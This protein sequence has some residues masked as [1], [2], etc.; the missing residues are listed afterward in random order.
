MAEWQQQ[1]DGVSVEQHRDL[2]T[3]GD[4]TQA[5]DLCRRLLRTANNLQRVEMAHLVLDR[6][7]NGGDSSDDVNALL[8]LLGNYVSPTRELTEEILSLL[9]FCDHRVLLIHHLPKPKKLLLLAN[10]DSV[11]RTRGFLCWKVAEVIA[12]RFS[13]L[14][15]RN[16]GALASSA[17]LFLDHL[18]RI[19]SVT[20]ESEGDGSYPSHILDLLCS[21]MALLT[22]RER[23]IYSLLMITIQKQL[24]SRAGASGMIQDQQAFRIQRSRSMRRDSA[25]EV[26]QLMAVFLTGHLL[27][28]QVVV[29]SRDRKSLANWML[30][31]LTSA[32]RDETLLHVMRFVRDE[33][34]RTR[35]LS[36]LEQERALLTSAISQVFRKKGLTWIPRDE[37]LERIEEDGDLVLAFD[38]ARRAPK[39]AK[40]GL[41][42]PLVMD[43][44]EFVRKMQFGVPPP[45]FRAMSS[46]DR[47]AS[48]KAMEQEYL[49]KICLLRELFH[50]YVEFS[51][52]LEMK[53]VD[54]GVLLPSGYKTAL[55]SESSGSLAPSA[56]SRVLWNLV[57]TLDVSVASTNSIAQ[58]YTSVTTGSRSKHESAKHYSRLAARLH[59]CLQQ[60]DQLEHILAVQKVNI[61]ACLESLDD[62]IADSRRAE[63][64]KVE[65]EWLLLEAS[66]A[67][68]MLNGQLRRVQGELPCASLFGLDF[69]VLCLAFEGQWKRFMEPPLS[70]SHELELLRAFRRHLQSDS[71]APSLVDDRIKCSA[72]NGGDNQRLLVSRSEGR[73]AVKYLCS[74]AA[75]LSRA[76]NN[77]EDDQTSGLDDE[78]A[79]DSAGLAAANALLRDVMTSSLTCIYETFLII[80]E[81]SHMSIATGD[82]S[83]SSTMME[84]LATGASSDDEVSRCENPHACNETFFRHLARQCLEM[85]ARFCLTCSPNGLPLTSLSNAVV[86]P[87][88]GRI[89]SLAK[90]RCSSPRWRHIVY[91]VVGSWAF[92]V[93]PAVGSLLLG[94]YLDD[95]RVLVDAAVSHETTG[96][97]KKRMQGNG[98]ESDEIELDEDASEEEEARRQAELAV[99]VDGEHLVLK[100]LTNES[101]P[102]FLDAV[103]LC[104]IASLYRAAPKRSNAQDLAESNPFEDYCRAMQ[105]FET[106]LQVF[107][108][109]E[110]SGFNLPVKTN[111]LVLRGGAFVTRSAK[112]LI[113]KCIAWRVE[114]SVSDAAGALSHLSVLFGSAHAMS[115]TMEAVQASFQERV[116]MKMQYDG[117][118]RRRGGWASEL[119]AKTYGK[120][121][122]TRRWITKTEAK[123]LPYFSHGIQELQD[124]LQDQSEVNNIQLEAAKAEWERTD[125]A[126]GDYDQRDAMLS[127]DEL[128]AA[129]RT[130][131]VEELTAALLKDWRPEVSS[132]RDED[133]SDYEDE[134]ELDGS[135]EL[136]EDS[137]SE[138]EDD[139]VDGFTVQSSQALRPANGSGIGSVAVLDGRKQPTVELQE[140][141]DLGFSTIVVNFKKQKKAH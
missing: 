100:S 93:S 108:R 26:K 128:V 40:G 103:F 126:F 12:L 50:C 105:V 6:L 15:R 66:I 127:D 30:R 121:Y 35:E 86:S 62:D 11:Q 117:S 119:L 54:A 7:R 13:E 113:S 18:H 60:R 81:E 140:N 9:L 137:A 98:S 87:S 49:M 41:A 68:R 73:R 45:A 43:A 2:I 21:T 29:D 10:A 31:L 4:V 5:T 64:R 1:Q 58:Q 101:L 51:P 19:A 69:R 131:Q 22:K 95:M 139:G 78:F 36:A 138:D 55:D 85:T 59:T 80:L 136:D 91:L 120:K 109:A 24:V 53:I 133:E 74:R 135:Q 130:L 107:A 77:D 114:Q 8:R 122:R 82:A 17:H 34:S 61:H 94:Q 97:Q 99:V 110:A 67:E 125:S 102:Y 42:T 118:G 79:G 75:E 124:F 65:L 72:S 71:V 129:C 112:S 56:L 48:E 90:Y 23:G 37:I 46:D 39:A 104:A 116:V 14:A 52:S 63:T 123:L 84:L 115:V 3:D 96:R 27:K 20:T 141:E 38:G 92:T 70:L 16:A 76:I 132:D 89:C 44:T 32:N 83:W 106:C 28:N 88:G 25:V 57:C 111:L 134:D 33:M 47:A